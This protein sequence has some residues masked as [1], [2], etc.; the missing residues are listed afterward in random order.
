MSLFLSYFQIRSYCT[1]PWITGIQDASLRM[2]GLSSW[3]AVGSETALGGKEREWGVEAKLTQD[4][5]E[6]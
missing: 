1:D 4:V 2:R 5:A 3:H 6:Q